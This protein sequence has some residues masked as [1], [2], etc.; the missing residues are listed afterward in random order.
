MQLKVTRPPEEFG[1]AAVIRKSRTGYPG[2][3]R[4]RRHGPLT[5]DYPLVVNPAYN[6]DRGPVPVNGTWLPCKF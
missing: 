3:I 6:R 2:F 4:G 5:L 1:L